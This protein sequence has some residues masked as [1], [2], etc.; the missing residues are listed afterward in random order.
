MGQVP[1]INIHDLDQL[2]AELAR[3]LDVTLTSDVL[4]PTL[5]L[6]RPTEVLNDGK[7]VGAT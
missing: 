1:F 4:K 2:T 6:E 5:R 3:L 7:N